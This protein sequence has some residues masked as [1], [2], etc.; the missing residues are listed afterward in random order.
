MF[1][2]LSLGY[3]VSF[4]TYPSNDTW[5]ASVSNPAHLPGDTRVVTVDHLNLAM[6][7]VG[8]MVLVGVALD[9]IALLSVAVATTMVDADVIMATI[10][11][12]AQVVITTG[13]TTLMMMTM[14]LITDWVPI[15]PF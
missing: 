6:I 4:Q 11:E 7:L 10:V 5:V 14:I 3:L 9:D 12:V 1:Q 13:T 8:T 15:W 2:T